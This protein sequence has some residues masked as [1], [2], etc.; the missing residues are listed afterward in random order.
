MTF[1]INICSTL[2][3]EVSVSELYHEAWV[4]RRMTGRDQIVLPPRWWLADQ[5]RLSLAGKWTW[6]HPTIRLKPTA[7]R[8]VAPKWLSETKKNTNF[9]IRVVFK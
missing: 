4:H 8:V 6:Q 2:Y 3:F 7:K 5:L 1:A 9:N